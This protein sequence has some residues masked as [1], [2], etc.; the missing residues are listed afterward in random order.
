LSTEQVEGLAKDL[1]SED[2]ALR[3]VAAQ[4]IGKFV[5]EPAKPLIKY[6]SEGNCIENLAVSSTCLN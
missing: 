5:L 4:H 3:I 1:A 2:K 6:I